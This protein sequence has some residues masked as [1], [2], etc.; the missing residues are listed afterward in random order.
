MKNLDSIYDLLKEY[1]IAT[2]DE[3]N[4]VTSINGWNLESSESIIYARTGLNSVDQ[5]LEDLGV[6][7]D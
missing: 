2:E 4:L 5:L 1:E 7:L 6:E 3:I